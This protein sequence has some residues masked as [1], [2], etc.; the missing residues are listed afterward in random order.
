VPPSTPIPLSVTPGAAPTSGLNIALDSILTIVGVLAGLTAFTAFPSDPLSLR[1]D[2][3][4]MTGT[5]W[6]TSS[7]GMAS[8][9]VV[10]TCLLLA[11]YVYPYRPVPFLVMVFNIVRVLF[12]VV[13]VGGTIVAALGAL[14]NHWEM[15]TMAWF[16]IRGLSIAALAFLYSRIAARRRAVIA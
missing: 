6:W 16:S 5:S 4:L 12:L 15:P 7:A 2:K 1:W 3:T 8:V 9:I 10:P 13:V 14:A 11:D